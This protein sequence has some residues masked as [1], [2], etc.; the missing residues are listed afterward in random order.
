MDRIII[1]GEPTSPFQY[2]YVYVNGERVER[3][4]VLMENLEDIVFA[5]LK[6]YNINH[7]D[8][9]GPRDYTT[10]IE[11]ILSNPQSIDYEYANI[12]FKYV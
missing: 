6:K 3:L 11:R 1:R 10:G 8:L 12:T 5:L 4:G 2:I 9:S 7:I